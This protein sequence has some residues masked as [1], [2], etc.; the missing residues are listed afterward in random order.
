MHRS[1]PGTPRRMRA[2]LLLLALAAFALPASPQTTGATASSPAAPLD[3]KQRLGLREKPGAALEWPGPVAVEGIVDPA[4][5]T[6]AP[7]DRVTLGI[8]GAADLALE[9]AVGADGGLVVPSVGVVPV[10]GSTLRDATE[11]VRRACAAAYPRSAITLSLARPGPM[12]VPITG[13]VVAPGTYEVFSTYR[14]ADLIALAGGTG[15]GADTRHVEVAHRDGTRI[16]ADLL[17]WRADGSASGN[18]V[19]RT[20][21][22]VQVPPAFATYRVRGAFPEAPPVAATTTLDRPFRAETRVVPA[23]AGDTL[24]FVLRAS[25]WLGTN[26]C[27][28][29]VWLERRGEPRR[30]VAL[31]VSAEVELR[32][33]DAIEIPFCREWVSVTGSIARPGFY[34]YLP[35]QVAADYVYL[36]GGPTELGRNGG[37][38]IVDDQGRKRAV[39]A[40]DTIAAGARIWVPNRRAYTVSSLLTPLGTAIAVIASLVALSR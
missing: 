3:L 36:A 21:D 26:A 33:G 9:L 40:A 17:A 32:P 37:W 7:G 31:G 1:N 15:G 11:S 20:G 24:A 10:A 25:G 35:G 8:W 29:G 39:A 22:R 28:D 5:Y 14:L 19:L 13:Q 23:R 6:L 34:P 4:Q 30:W 12:R 16:E 18:P 2:G 38:K 27:A